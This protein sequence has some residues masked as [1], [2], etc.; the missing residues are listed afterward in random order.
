MIYLLPVQI[1]ILFNTTVVVVKES[2]YQVS[3]KG[4]LIIFYPFNM[5]LLNSYNYRLNDS[6]LPSYEVYLDM[7]PFYN[8]SSNNK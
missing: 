8:Y 3:V 4:D 2:K 6:I 1:S 5:P 7:T